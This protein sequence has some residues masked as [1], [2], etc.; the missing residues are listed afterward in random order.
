MRFGALPAGRVVARS[1]ARGRVVE[2]AL[3]VRV[4]ARTCLI[5]RIAEVL[6]GAAERALGFDNLDV[7]FRQVVHEARGD[8]G[9]IEPARAPILRE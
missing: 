9:L 5:E 2:P 6:I 7:A 8:G 3:A 1:E 4:A